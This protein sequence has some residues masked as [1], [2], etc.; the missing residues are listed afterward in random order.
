MSAQTIRA[1]CLAEGLK[2]P[3][4]HQWRR[5]LRLRDAERRAPEV[6]AKER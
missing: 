1:F 4:F 6:Q 5:Q 2:E 3:S